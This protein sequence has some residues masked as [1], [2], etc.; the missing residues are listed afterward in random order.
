MFHFQRTT[1][2]QYTATA[3]VFLCNCAVPELVMSLFTRM[4][5]QQFQGIPYFRFFVLGDFL[6]SPGI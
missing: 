4:P 3:A 6:A 1:W 2:D 5:E